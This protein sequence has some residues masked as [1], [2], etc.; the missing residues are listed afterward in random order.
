MFDHHRQGNSSTSLSVR[1]QI[2]VD[3]EEDNKEDRTSS[4]QITTLATSVDGQWLA[5][6]DTDGWINVFNLDGIQVFMSQTTYVTL[7]L[8]T[9]PYVAPLHTPQNALRT[10]LTHFRHD[11]LSLFDNRNAK[12]FNTDI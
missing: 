3:I 7:F 6:A 12:Q 8:L 11:P 9:T 10:L 4:A 1:L 2:H 5:S